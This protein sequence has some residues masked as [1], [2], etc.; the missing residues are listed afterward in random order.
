MHRN[1]EDS[2]DSYEKPKNRHHNVLPWILVILLLCFEGYRLYAGSHSQTKEVTPVEDHDLTLENNGVMGYTAADFGKVIIEKSSREKQLIVDEEEVCVPTEITMAGAFNLKIFTKTAHETVYGTGQYTINLEN[3]T[4]DDIKFDQDTYTVTVT[5]PYPE[6]HNVSFDP[7][8]T[9][10]GS[11]DRGWLA[12]GDVKLSQE[13]QK[14]FETTAV[15]KLTDRLNEQDCFDRAEKFA[16]LSAYEMY[17]PVVS[18]VSP[19]FKVNIEV[20]SR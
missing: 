11:T 2:Y 3:I 10:I 7:S 12:F 8:K 16:K 9:V 20:A 15:S 18:S 19:E 5:I 17:Q 13:Q 1:D 4:E 6:L 14:D